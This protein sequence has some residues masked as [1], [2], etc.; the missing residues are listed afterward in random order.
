MA[1][2]MRDVTGFERNQDQVS[3]QEYP[4]FWEALS[5]EAA[6]EKLAR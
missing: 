1:V 5:D 3:S 4:S 6:H 2:M